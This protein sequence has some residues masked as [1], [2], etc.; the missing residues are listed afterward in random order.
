MLAKVSSI[1]C[2][3]SQQIGKLLTVAALAAIG[4]FGHR[5][6][7]TLPG[8]GKE[9][10][11]ATETRTSAL[12]GPATADAI[13]PLRVDFQSADAITRSGITTVASPS[14]M[15]SRIARRLR[16]AG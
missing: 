12:Y 9:A 16:W 6:E 15:N 5:S 4:L 7:W 2:A 11:T 8:L 3:F 13:D 10:T 14:S 1:L